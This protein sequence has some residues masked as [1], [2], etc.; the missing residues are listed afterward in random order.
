MNMLPLV[1]K[2]AVAIV[3]MFDLTRKTTLT[4][5]KDWYRQSRAH[6]KTFIP[7]LVG[8][9]YDKF[10]EFGQEEKVEIYNMAKKYAAAMKAPMVFCSAQA[11]LN[12]NEVFKIILCRAFKLKCTIPKVSTP[13]EAIIEYENPS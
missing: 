1:C 9:K 8:T 2:D 5:V 11:S 3:F 10:K 13:G 7:F 4:S 6:N 12:V